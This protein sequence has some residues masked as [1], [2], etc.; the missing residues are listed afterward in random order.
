M[1]IN[2][3]DGIIYKAS[4]EPF[5]SEQA[6]K[7]RAG[8]LK[9]DGIIATPIQYE[10]G[11]YV[12][13]REPEPEGERLRYKFWEEPNSLFVDKTKLDPRFEYRV[14]N[15]DDN[16]WRNRVSTLNRAGWEKVQDDVPMNSG[17]VGMPSQIGGTAS[18][19]VG[20]GVRGYLMRKPKKWYKEDYAEKQRINDQIMQQ[21]KTAPGSIDGGAK[22][23]ND[24]RIGYSEEVLTG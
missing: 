11:G 5:E 13:V 20:K 19:P 14:V 21:I 22:P 7:M 18:L 4:G 8:I 16:F 17:G 12:L 15:D 6:A 1:S 9:R 24:S 23:M 10:G 2:E 3:K